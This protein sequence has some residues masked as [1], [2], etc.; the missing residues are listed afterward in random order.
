V[1]LD[2]Q[3][4]G[5]DM[6]RVGKILIANP[7]MTDDNPF[8]KTVIY[9]YADDPVQGTTGVILN[10]PSETTIQDLF[11]DHKVTYPSKSP[12]VHV[13]GPVNRTAIVLLHTD[14]WNS[15][16]TAHAGN[17]LLISSDKLMFL[18]MSQGNEPI[19]WRMMIGLSSWAPDQLDMEMRGQF[20]YNKSHQWLTAEPS[21]DI[22]FGYDGEEQWN[23][24][25]ELCSQQIIDQWF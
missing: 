20:P 21:E 18:K 25:L 4:I 19:Y 6:S 9:I 11:Y 5:V 10:K 23:K 22:L 13:G 2:Q 24:A 7:T 8:A 17:N 12:M 16:N 1:V 14:D 3:E 15:Q